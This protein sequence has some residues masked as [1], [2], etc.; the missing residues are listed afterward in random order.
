MKDDKSRNKEIKSIEKKFVKNADG[1]QG[2]KK[3]VRKNN[4]KSSR[5]SEQITLSDCGPETALQW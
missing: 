5:Q 4:A 1:K 3:V 2:P